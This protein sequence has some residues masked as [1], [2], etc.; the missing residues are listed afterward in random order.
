LKKLDLDWW[1]LK[2]SEDYL[3]RQPIATWNPARGVWETSQVNL[4]CGHLELWQEVWPTSGMTANGQV[5]ELPTQGHRTTALESSLL[6][7][8]TASQGEGGALG[9]EEA[10]KRGNTVGIR[11][12]A[13]DIAKANG[14]K[15]SRAVLPTP[16]AI[17]SRNATSGRKPGSQHHPGVTLHDLVFDGSLMPIPMSRDY[18]GDTA[19]H[20]RNGKVQVDS[21]ERAIFHS[22]EVL[23]PTTRTSMGRPSQKEIDDGNPKTR[24]ETKVMLGEVN[25]G[26]F[27]PAIRRWEETLGRPSPAPTKPDG[28][29]GAHR[30]SSAFTE[31]LMGLPEG[32]ITDCGLTRNEELKACGNGV[33]PQQAELALRV[34]LEGVSI[35]RGGGQVNLPTPTVSDTFTDNL[36]S[37][38]QKPGSMHSVTLP[39]AVR[40]VSGRI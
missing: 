12:Q 6:R 26:K 5:F 15:V 39:Q 17:Q 14:E 37:S 10:R 4:L 35:P 38:Q 40:W 23:L 9:E 33:V 32:W 29:D 18:K 11:D 36:A 34:L 22:G 3:A 24:I 7:S 30:L 28:K 8:P 25:W 16:T 20:E 21:V 13:M 19:P 2:M 1:L 27:E 31:W